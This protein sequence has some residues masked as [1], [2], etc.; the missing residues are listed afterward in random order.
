MPNWKIRIKVEENESVENI[1]NTLKGM[2]DDK[3]DTPSLIVQELVNDKNEYYSHIQGLLVSHESERKLRSVLKQMFGHVA[4]NKKYSMSNKHN[5]WSYY[6]AYLMKNSNHAKHPTKVLYAGGRTD[7]DLEDL[8]KL[9]NEKPRKQKTTD[10]TKEETLFEDLKKYLDTLEP[11]KTKMSLVKSIIQYYKN[12]GRVLHKVTI[13]RFAETY[14]AFSSNEI[15]DELCESI[16][17]ETCFREEACL[18]QMRRDMT[19]DCPYC[20]KHKHCGDYPCP[21]HTCTIDEE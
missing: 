9:Y 12:S 3:S 17:M 13:A 5:D 19:K 6:C 21:Y 2:M 14:V 1:V 16:L 7:K 18:S 10:K 20:L 8:I 4:G 15:P 11:Y